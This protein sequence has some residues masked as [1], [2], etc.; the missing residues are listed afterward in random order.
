MCKKDHVL[1]LFRP[2]FLSIMEPPLFFSEDLGNSASATFGGKLEMCVCAHMCTQEPGGDGGSCTQR[3]VRLS[4]QIG[5]RRGHSWGCPRV[6]RKQRSGRCLS[7]PA[8]VWSGISPWGR[9]PISSTLLSLTSQSTL[10]ALCEDPAHSLPWAVV[11]I[12]FAAIQFESIQFNMV[13]LCARC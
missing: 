13:G 9:V 12:L 3:V 6:G 10:F 4:E 5:K 2:I 7:C 11:L 8:N 1:S